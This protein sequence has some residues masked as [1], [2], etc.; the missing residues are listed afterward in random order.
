ME[1]EFQAAP[2]RCPNHI[3][4]VGIDMHTFTRN[5]HTAPWKDYGAEIFNV[6]IT[7]FV[8]TGCGRGA[9][10]LNLEDEVCR[11]LLSPYIAVFLLLTNVE[12]FLLHRFEQKALTIS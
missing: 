3:Q 11:I 9:L 6:N 4:L 2:D 7:G 10:S 12:A 1:S 5:D 8:D